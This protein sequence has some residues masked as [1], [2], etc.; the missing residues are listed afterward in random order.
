MPYQL[1]QYVRAHNRGIQARHIVGG[2][3][4]AL[5]SAKALYDR[6]P[7]M[8]FSKTQR[9]ST[10]QIVRASHEAKNIDGTYNEFPMSHLASTFDIQ[11][12]NPIIQGTGA[13]NRTGRD[14][15][16]EYV[17]LRFDLSST[18]VNSTDLYRLM[19]VWDT[20]TRGA[21]PAYADILSAA[22][23]VI[24]PVNFDNTHRFK[25]LYDS[26]AHNIT[27]ESSGLSFFRGV[28]VVV[29]VNKK[30]HYYNASNTG[31]VTDIDSG[32]LF[33]IDVCSQGVV[34]MA[35]QGRVVFRDV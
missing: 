5:G 14:V 21:T 22:A 7:A 19:V 29:P 25:V 24:S 33:L 10:A 16:I 30:A 20:E 12:L 1:G 32:G 3:S 13:G 6:L 31:T 11:L 8:Q 9:I 27:S 26:S 15:L 34:N 18:A 23:G 35:V 4:L 17:D 28:H 2:A